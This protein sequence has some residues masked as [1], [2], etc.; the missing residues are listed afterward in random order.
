MSPISERM[1]VLFIITD[2]QRADHLGCSGNPILKTPNIDKFANEGVRFTNAYVAN[3][4]CMPNRA[5]LLTGLYPNM[6]G[7]RSNGINLPTNVPTI[8]QALQKKGYHTVN[9]GKMHLQWHFLPF[10]RKSSSVEHAAKWDDINTFSKMK[11]IFNSPYYGFDE[12]EISIGHGDICGGHYLDWL[13]EKVLNNT[14]FM[15]E[16]IGKRTFENERTIFN[17]LLK[18]RRKRKPFT[19]IYETEMPEELYPTTFVAERTIA[20]LERYAKGEYGNKPF[21]MHC[22]FPD[23]H[24]PVGP[25]GKYHEM[26]KPENITLPPSYTDIENIYHHKFLGQ[27]LKKPPFRGTLIRES[28][29]E[30]VRKFTALT[31]G[32]L[33]MIDHGVGKILTSLEKLGLED[34]TMVIYT[35]DHG[36]LMGDH[37][38]CLKGPNPFNGVL[39]VPLIWKVPGLT[40]RAISDSLVSSIDIPKT[41]L[42]LLGIGQRRQPPD[43]QGYDI[44]PILDN[45]NMKI[46]NCCLIEEDEEV[47]PYKIRLR[48]L[49]TEDYKIT[50]YEGLRDY[51]DIFDRK[52]DPNELHNLWY[53]DKDLRNE[54]V[55]ELFHENLKAQSCYPHR[56]AL[57]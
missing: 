40:K 26:Y 46:R 25:P 30:E 1:N 55:N 15:K 9:V 41:I 39:Q 52:N 6:H 35:S 24:H 13:K 4:M 23:P 3:P 14:S 42:N 51:G 19:F 38:M 54:L 32:S 56:Q 11:E 50:L 2:Q 20:F 18:L 21:F 16:L 31:Y 36:D 17:D 37:G 12:V 57:T 7:L 44:T 49:V 22:S 48:H 45:P 53:K 5:T 43:M 29:E 8:T 10:Q 27:Y 47:D 34:N 28:A 33:S